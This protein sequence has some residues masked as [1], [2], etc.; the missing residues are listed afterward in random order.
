MNER[1]FL[2]PQDGELYLESWYHRQNI[3]LACVI[4]AFELNNG[5]AFDI[6][7]DNLKRMDFQSVAV[8]SL[9]ADFAMNLTRR[10]MESD[11]PEEAE[12]CAA[13]ASYVSKEMMKKLKKDL[14]EH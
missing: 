8:I 11:V 2:N 12:Q 9:I 6:N 5:M 14:T 10:A 3:D 4:E 1:I 7:P 13:T